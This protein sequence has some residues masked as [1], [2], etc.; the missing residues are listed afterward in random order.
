V[1]TFAGHS[2]K[3]ISSNEL[4]QNDYLET[5]INKALKEPLQ[6]TQQIKLLTPKKF[7]T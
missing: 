3:T 4:P 1:N 6:I 2:G 5:K 7:K